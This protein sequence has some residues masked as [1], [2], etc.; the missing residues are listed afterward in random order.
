MKPGGRAPGSDESE[1]KVREIF[2]DMVRNKIAASLG[3][4]RL[5]QIRSAG[6]KTDPAGPAV[7]EI[8]EPEKTAAKDRKAR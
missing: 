4:E 1:A 5:L 8:P 3:Q 6:V 2:H 7:A